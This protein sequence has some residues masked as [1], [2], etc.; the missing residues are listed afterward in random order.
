MDRGHWI[1]PCKHEG[2]K[3]RGIRGDMWFEAPFSQ[4][5]G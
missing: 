5:G 3:V 4:T 1:R 2:K